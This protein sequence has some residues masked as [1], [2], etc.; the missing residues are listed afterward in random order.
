MEQHPGIEKLRV[1]MYPVFKDKPAAVALVRHALRT[2][3]NPSLRRPVSSRDSGRSE[4]S[5]AMGE[6]P[7]NS[8]SRWRA[9]PRLRHRY[10]LGRDGLVS[11]RHELTT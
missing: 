2:W 5:Q 8:A 7:K 9:L 6:L 3:K 10:L 1:K 4:L 11:N